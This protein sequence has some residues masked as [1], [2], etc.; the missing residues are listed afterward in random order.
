VS[1]RK[2]L[3]V[4][5]EEDVRLPLRRFLI[6]K[7]YTVLEAGG[8]GS[9]RE[10]LRGQSVD[11]AVVDFS[12][13]DGDGLDVLRS[14]KAQ[15]ASL[16]VVLLTGHG[17]IDLA[18]TAIKEGA[19]QFFTKPVELP[20]LLVVIERALDNRRMRQV[21]LAGKSSQARQA[22]DPFFGESPAMRKL[23]AE[24]TRVVA[25]P[26]PVLI[27]G[28][29]GS[30]KGVL[31]R[32]VH[33]NG[34]RAD[35]PFV[36]LNC[37]GLS[38][39]LLESELFG[40]EKGA[41]TGAVAAKPGL[42]EMANKGTVFL[43]EIGDIDLQVQA[44]LLKVVEDLRFRRLGDVRDRVVD[45][46]LV[47]ATHRDLARLVQEQKFREDLYYRISAL[48][49]V[50]PALRDRGQDVVLLARRLV[51]RISAEMGRP[52]MRLSAAAEQA[53]GSRSWPGNVRQLRNVLER[54][55]LLSDHSTLEPADLGE[56]PAP[57]AVGSTPGPRMTLA[58]A[59]RLHIEAVL[60]EERG[61]V[62]RAAEVLGIS[63]SSLYERIKKHG[64]V[65]GK[66]AED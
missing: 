25:S 52:G 57:A 19:E 27:Q 66:R 7:G 41:F 40:H 59:E 11:A 15:D 5:D 62:S 22:V 32:W 4:D 20:A 45:V 64:I 2:I 49:L 13:A 23:A 26:L 36:D 58:E 12:L 63:R 16:P 10:V 44:K 6:G 61:A 34:P 17:T 8:L 29:T 39:E 37:A 54:A 24:A 48:P 46:R 18:V 30:G 65:V 47:A 51:Q 9:A 28:E 31:A 38:R 42:L 14:L 33:Q 1:D 56:G 50:V 53:L 21:S 35:E 60:R 3:L 55:A 43:D